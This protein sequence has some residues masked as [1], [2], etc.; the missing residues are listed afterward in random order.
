MVKRRGI[1]VLDLV[2]FVPAGAQA[3][4]PDDVAG[5]LESFAVLDHHPI[6]SDDAYVHFGTVQS[7]TIDL[8]R[9]TGSSRPAEAPDLTVGSTSVFSSRDAPETP[10]TRS[11]RLLP[12]LSS[13]WSWTPSRSRQASN[14]GGSSGRPAPRR[15]A[16][17]R[18]PR[19]SACPTLPARPASLPVG[20]FGSPW[21]TRAQST[22]ASC[23]FRTSSTRNSRR[24][25]RPGKRFTALATPAFSF[26]GASDKPPPPMI[27]SK[28][29]YREEAARPLARFGRHT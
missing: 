23:S 21:A 3:L 6:T 27:A 1:S 10:G 18:S 20:P 11:N 2:S 7:P 4:I 16:W 13:T 24:D 9:I 8:L 25:R 29:A 26:D 19:S 14:P 22:S 15:G 5:L 12:T 28:L 17:S